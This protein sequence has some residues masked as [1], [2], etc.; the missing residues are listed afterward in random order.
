MLAITE[1]TGEILGSRK[2]SMK[3]ESNALF[4]QRF[5]LPPEIH[6]KYIEI[7]LTLFLF[8]KLGTFSS[9]GPK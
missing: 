8:E 6:R 1:K 3:I 9:S 7:E 4:F 5:I 2:F